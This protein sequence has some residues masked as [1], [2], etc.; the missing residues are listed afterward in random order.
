MSVVLVS[1]CKC[2]IARSLG[3]EGPG[4]LLAMVHMAR[5]SSVYLCELPAMAVR[6]RLRVATC[7]QERLAHTRVHQ[8]RGHA[9]MAKGNTTQR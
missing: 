1:V 8:H 2:I 7:W 5:R 3:P 9:G 6:Q 4:R